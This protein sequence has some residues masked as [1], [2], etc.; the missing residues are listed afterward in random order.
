IKFLSVVP[1]PEMRTAIGSSADARLLPPDIEL[2]FLVADVDFDW[3]YARNWI[4]GE[5][6]GERL[7]ADV[8]GKLHDRPIKGFRS[9]DNANLNPIG[10]LQSQILP[11]ILHQT[12]K[13]TRQALRN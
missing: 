2:H 6:L 4:R 3:I 8:F 7:A 1:P 5:H 9:A 10:E 13:I 11:P 12:H